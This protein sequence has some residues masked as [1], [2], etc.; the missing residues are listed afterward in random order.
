MHALGFFL[1][2]A[3]LTMRPEAPPPPLFV[4]PLIP[5]AL[6]LTYTPA[7]STLNADSQHLNILNLKL[8]LDLATYPVNGDDLF[9]NLKKANLWQSPPTPQ[10]KMPSFKDLTGLQK[11]LY[12]LQWCIRNHLQN[13]CTCIKRLVHQSFSIHL[14]A[15]LHLTENQC[16]NRGWEISASCHLKWIR[17]LVSYMMRSWGLQAPE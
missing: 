15:L 10:E 6:L 1:I 5:R 16:C 8:L 17:L 11:F 4:K 13:A 7:F 2:F 9:H 14:P 12:S 3:I